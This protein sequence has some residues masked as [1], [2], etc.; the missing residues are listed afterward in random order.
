[1]NAFK[2]CL[3]AQVRLDQN[4]NMFNSRPEPKSRQTRALLFQTAL[5]LF[6]EKGFEA[7]TMRDIA[8]K[9]RTALG[10]AYYY[11]PSKEAI[12]QDYYQSVQ[13]EHSGRV[14]EALARG[15]LD[16]KARLRAATHAKLDVI[17]E[18]RKLLGTIFRYAGEPDHPL[19]C[20]GP[21]TREVRSASIATFAEAIADEP[22]PKDIAELLPVALWALHMAIMVYFI[23]DNSP[24]QQRTRKL[25]DGALELALRL[26]ALAKFPLMRPF[27]GKLVALLR[28]A[29][30]LPQPEPIQQLQPVRG[31]P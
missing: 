30:L 19:S 8:A 14:R 12:V 17:A 6:R 29:D 24:N 18:D 7:T 21:A 31:T 25:V 16:L 11:F 27:R 10:A 3:T 26:I 9:A 2:F 13:D 20:L 23:Y 5:R 1:M 28:S 4:L 15:D 22:L